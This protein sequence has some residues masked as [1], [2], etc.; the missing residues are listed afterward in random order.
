MCIKSKKALTK[1][2]HCEIILS[3]GILLGKHPQL[4]LAP[5]KLIIAPFVMSFEDLNP[6]L[7]DFTALIIQAPL[8]QV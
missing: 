8:L 3:G 6:D 7:F 5:P 1:V 4:T 2:I